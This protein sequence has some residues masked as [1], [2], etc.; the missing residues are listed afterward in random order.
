M[1]RYQAGPQGIAASNHRG[2]RQ[3]PFDQNPM[4]GRL[5]Q[6]FPGCRRCFTSDNHGNLIMVEQGTGS[7]KKKLYYHNALILMKS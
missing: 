6:S 4:Q 5:W 1:V 2:K 7:A 3:A